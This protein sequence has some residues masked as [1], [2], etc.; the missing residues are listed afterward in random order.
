M[1]KYTK[2]CCCPRLDGTSHDLKLARETG[3]AMA[4]EL[5][6]ISEYIYL[7]IVFEDALPELSKM[8]G[9][10]AMEEMEHYRTL[11]RLISKLGGDPAQRTAV[12]DSGGIDLSEDRPCRATVAAARSLRA[13]VMTERQASANYIRLGHMAERSGQLPAADLFRRLAEDERRH[14]SAQESMLI[15]F[16]SPVPRS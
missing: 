4:A 13:N 9:K 2:N 1:E 7:S 16:S 15:P 3:R 11:G 10:L 8:F 6:S 5:N 14:A 12:R